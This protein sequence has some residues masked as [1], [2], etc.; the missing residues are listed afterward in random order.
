LARS[1]FVIKIRFYLDIAGGKKDAPTLAACGYLAT[2]E[3]WREAGKV[4]GRI[5]ESAKADEFH[6]TDFYVSRF[7]GNVTRGVVI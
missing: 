3:R 4:W 5:L 2:E 7:S 1:F 6:A